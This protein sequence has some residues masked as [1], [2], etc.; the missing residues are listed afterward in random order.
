MNSLED[1]LREAYHAAADTVRPETVLPGGVR[2]LP[3]R[4]A[5]PGARCWYRLRPLVP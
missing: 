4:G 1:R 2:G 3:G 5:G